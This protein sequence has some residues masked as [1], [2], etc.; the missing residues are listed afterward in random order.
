MKCLN[1]N[2]ELL[3]GSEFCP[4][5]GTKCSNVETEVIENYELKND[6]NNVKDEEASCWAK[7]AKVS[8]ILGI[9]TLCTF[10]IP[11][12]GLLAIETGIPGIVFG[13]LGKRTKKPI[14]KE[15]ANSG[16]TKSLV[17]TILSVV[18]FFIWY[19]II[20]FTAYSS[21]GY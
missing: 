19:I 16:F 10:W 4:Y 5:C 7:F 18:V 14:A 1:C 8:N 3:E 21:M 6:T 11:F 12:I 15:Q 20:L 2:A 13:A 9:I 17:G